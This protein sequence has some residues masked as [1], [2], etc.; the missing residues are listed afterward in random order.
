MKLTLVLIISLSALLG[1]LL[2]DDELDPG[3]AAWASLT[4][5]DEASESEAFHYLFGM[6]AHA[7]EQPAVVGKDLLQAYRGQEEKFT[8]S[9]QSFQFDGYPAN[10][11]LTLPEGGVYCHLRKNNCFDTL[12]GSSD[13]ISDELD[14]HTVLLDRY[15]EFL[16]YDDFR[17]LTKPSVYVPM[18][19]YQ[20]LEKGNRLNG[21]LILRK[22]SEGQEQVAVDILYADISRQRRLLKKADTLITKMVATSLLANDLDLLANLHA[23]GYIKNPPELARLTLD[24]RSLYLPMIREFG[25]SVS[26]HSDLDGNPEFFGEGGSA[27]SWLIRVIFK[28]NMSINKAFPIYA[29]VHKLSLDAPADFAVGRASLEAFADAEAEGMLSIRNFGGDILTRVA[30]P[31]FAQYVSRMHDLDCKIK[32]LNIV[33]APGNDERLFDGSADAD[34]T[35]I[36]NPYD[37]DEVPYLNHETGKLCYSGP[38]ND[39][40]EVRCIRI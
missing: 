23:A 40:N 32:L 7:S 1:L 11:R 25:I 38:A 37:A 34:H 2:I 39:R 36:S 17:T 28:P 12:L 22:I 31:D 15:R 5:D 4:M 26:L 6:M 27:P 8:G 18:P 3:P 33:L 14:R 13:L 21:F 30:M 16:S 29:A 19:E 9:F 24:E 35:G 10:K 20:Y